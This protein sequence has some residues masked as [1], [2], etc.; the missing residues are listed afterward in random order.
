[1]PRISG[2]DSRDNDSKMMGKPR[3][4]ATIEPIKGD[5]VFVADS[6]GRIYG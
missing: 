1:M 5:T 4:I 2:F 6:V 3:S